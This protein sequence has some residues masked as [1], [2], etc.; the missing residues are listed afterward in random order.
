MDLKFSKENLMEQTFTT[1]SKKTCQV[2]EEEE[3]DEN[4]NECEDEC[5]DE[6]VIELNDEF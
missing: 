1:R 4:E 5:E 6:C 3:D 2:N